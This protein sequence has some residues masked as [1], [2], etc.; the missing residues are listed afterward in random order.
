MALRQ[1]G[2]GQ[3]TEKE[4]KKMMENLTVTQLT[5]KGRILDL[6]PVHAD[7]PG[8]HGQHNAM[9]IAAAPGRGSRCA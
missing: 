6:R 1:N 3:L 2:D 8:E 5:K 7:R 4:I 9:A